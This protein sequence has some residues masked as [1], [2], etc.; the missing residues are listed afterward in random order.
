VAADTPTLLVAGQIIA[1]DL[2]LDSINGRDQLGRHFRAEE[3][4][5]VEK[6]ALPYVLAPELIVVLNGVRL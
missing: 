4:R 6:S 5:D 2:W 1:V 3:L